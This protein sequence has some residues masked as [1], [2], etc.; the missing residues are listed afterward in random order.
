[1][2]KSSQ[3]H[4]EQMIRARKEFKRSFDTK[5]NKLLR[6]INVP[7][8]VTRKLG[9]LTIEAP[10]VFIAKYSW[11]S[12][13]LD[14]LQ[15]E[16]NIDISN[17]DVSKIDFDEEAG[18]YAENMISNTQNINDPTMASQLFQDKTLSN[19]VI[20]S[21]FFTF[22]S[23][24]INNSNNLRS[25]LANILHGS[26]EQKVNAGYQLAASLSELV[27]YDLIKKSIKLSIGAV[28]G[29][30]LQSILGEEE[31]KKIDEGLLK[32]SS[33]NIINALFFDGLGNGIST[34]LKDLSD[35]SF[36]KNILG[37]PNFNFLNEYRPQTVTPVDILSRYA[38]SIGNAVQLSQ[39][40]YDNGRY[41]FSDKLSGY[42]TYKGENGFEK[43]KYYNKLT[44]EQKT[45]GK[46][47]FFIDLG[48]TTTGISI[49]EFTQLSREFNRT[50]KKTV[51][52]VQTQN[53][54]SINRKAKNL[55][56][57]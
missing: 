52:P 13:Y 25:S 22:S 45:L 46:I 1:M 26:K 10:D 9:E 44:D 15:K 11:V 14:Y 2:R 37:D 51:E 53:K 56:M 6:G 33:L 5:L 19:R 23:F 3:L 12:Y 55:E 24:S 32:Q 42:T 16:K 4:T 41:A 54:T 43:T 27:S 50:L 31:E 47:A 29:T 28:S 34:P 18:A 48:S 35:Y 57:E 39:R 17:V 21:L 8:E 36:G 7:F 20:R 40:I 49:S 30:I 38:G